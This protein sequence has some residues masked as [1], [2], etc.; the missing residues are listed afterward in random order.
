VIL[1]E[2]GADAL[3][4]HRGDRT[5]RWT[6]EFQAWLI[7]ETMQSALA[8]PFIVGTAPWLLKDFRSPRRP[9][10]KFQQY[11]NRKGLTD[12]LGR[13]KLAWQTVRDHYDRLAAAAPAPKN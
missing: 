2:F 6:E 9:H 5:E 13:P 8:T 1:S 12:E 7:D 11:W 10:G 4:G 3:R